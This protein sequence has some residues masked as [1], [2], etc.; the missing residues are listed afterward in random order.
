MSMTAVEARDALAAISAAIT[1]EVD[2]L[3][4]LTDRFD[5]ELGTDPGVAALID[6]CT[7]AIDQI[8]DVVST[9]INGAVGFFAAQTLIKPE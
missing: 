8:R 3:D 9:K 4:K 7:T 1:I 5:K 6:D 2:K